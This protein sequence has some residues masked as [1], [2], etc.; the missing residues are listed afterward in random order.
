MIIV[1][2]LIVGGLSSTTHCGTICFER[3]KIEWIQRKIENLTMILDI[4]CYCFIHIDC[5]T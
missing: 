5:E 3:T 2:A 1:T 4:F